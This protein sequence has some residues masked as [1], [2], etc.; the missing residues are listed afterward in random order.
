MVRKHL[1]I[2]H[3]I[4]LYHPQKSSKIKTISNNYIH[5]KNIPTYVVKIEIDREVKLMIILSSCK[6]LL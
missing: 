2:Y 1:N 3:L 6:M 4:H 5:I